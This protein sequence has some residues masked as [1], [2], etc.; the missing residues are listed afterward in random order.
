MSEVEVLFGDDV[1]V[2]TIARLLT[3][4]IQLFG[5]YVIMHGHASPG[6]G[7]QGGVIIGASFILLA[8]SLGL[9]EAKKRL[10]ESARL[11]MEGAGVLLYALIGIACILAGGYFLQ[12]RMEFLF[13]PHVVSEI[14][15][16][17][18]EIC[19]GITVMAMIV[20]IFYSMAGD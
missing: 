6:G 18:V 20:T 2:R 7:F 1:I 16:S 3:P 9:P 14:L 5:L 19:I 17:A 11:P 13:P 10:K 8:I 4:F 12:Y 15:I